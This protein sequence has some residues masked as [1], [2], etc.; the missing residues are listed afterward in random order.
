MNIIVKSTRKKHCGPRNMLAICEQHEREVGPRPIVGSTWKGEERQKA[1]TAQ[2][3]WDAGL[4]AKSP[5]IR[6][7]VANDVVEIAHNGRIIPKR[8]R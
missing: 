8:R 6:E 7:S 5:L 1:L 2:R 4:M 3:H